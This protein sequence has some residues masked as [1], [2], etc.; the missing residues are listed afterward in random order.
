VSLEDLSI[1]TGNKKGKILATTLDEATGK[2]LDNRK[3]P[4]PRTGELDNRGSQY[5]LA[6]Y[7]AQALAGQSE[8]PELKAHFAPLA[9]S[10]AENE[11]KIVAEFK[12]VQG[13]PVDIGGYFMPDPV[14]TVAVMRPSPTFNAILNAARI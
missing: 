6:M 2:L 5:Y 9:K 7:W 10:L 1:K 8:D 3:S 13:K 11:E 4:T 12:A 14:K